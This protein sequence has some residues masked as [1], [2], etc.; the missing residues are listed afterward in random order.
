M[1]PLNELEIVQ[2]RQIEGLSIFLN[3]ID[4]RTPP[5]PYGVGFN[6]GA[7]PSA[8]RGLREK[9]FCGPSGQNGAFQP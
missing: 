4:Y 3:T 6:L 2:H 1:Y 5:Y 8:F 9:K 7:G